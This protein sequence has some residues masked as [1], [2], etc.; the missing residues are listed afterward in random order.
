MGLGANARRS[1]EARPQSP[2]QLAAYKR[3]RRRSPPR[4]AR[5]AA[6]GRYVREVGAHIGRDRRQ[7]AQRLALQQ[8]SDNHQ[9]G[10]GDAQGARARKKKES[11]AQEK[12]KR[13]TI[14]EFVEPE[15]CK[16][17]ANPPNSLDWAHEVKFDGYRIQ[18][19]VENG[20]ARLRTRKK[21]DW[22]ARFPEIAKDCGVL[23]DGIFDGEIV[24]LDKD[25][26]ADFAMLQ[27]ALF[28]KKT[29]NLVF[30]VFDL[31]FFEGLD[32]R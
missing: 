16:I 26:V 15:L 2:S 5:Y 23:P 30:F 21:L 28:N 13:V 12:E 1:R 11:R 3:A 18:A 6:Q 4:R 31:P 8:G 7:I 19:R 32:L 10:D 14:P 25:G 20:H 29:A 22:S 9:A 17:L 27:S 24:A